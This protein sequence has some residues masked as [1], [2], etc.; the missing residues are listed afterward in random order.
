[1]TLKGCWRFCLFRRSLEVSDP[2]SGLSRRCR[3]SPVG[4]RGAG[5]AHLD[6]SLDDELKLSLDAGENA[7]R[8]PRATAV[9]SARQMQS[10]VVLR[11][12]TWLFPS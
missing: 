9:L 1:L 11:G 2:P 6:W 3:I 7:H 4:L 5:P 8:V 12:P 10:G